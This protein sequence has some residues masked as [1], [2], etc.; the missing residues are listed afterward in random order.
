MIGSATVVVTQLT[1]TATIHFC[2]IV[3]YSGSHVDY[4]DTQLSLKIKVSYSVFKGI[5]L[6][7]GDK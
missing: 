1:V 4:D 3:G 7:V 5:F 2:K 6:K